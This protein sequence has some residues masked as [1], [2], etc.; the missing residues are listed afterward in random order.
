MSKQS[1]ALGSAHHFIGAASII[2]GQIH[3]MQT[4]ENVGKL[5]A[6]VG[7]CL[8]M[9]KKHVWNACSNQLDADDAAQRQP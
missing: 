1:D 7:I 3:A 4:D 2:L 5:L 9:A 6:S 8:E